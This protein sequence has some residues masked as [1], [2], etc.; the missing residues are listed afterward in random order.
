MGQSKGE[1]MKTKGVVRTSSQKWGFLTLHKWVKKVWMDLGR[2]TGERYVPY[3]VVSNQQ[4]EFVRKGLK[5]E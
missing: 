3:V 2:G 5:G 4:S 1:L